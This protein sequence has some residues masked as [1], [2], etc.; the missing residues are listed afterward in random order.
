MLQERQVLHIVAG[1]H[2]WTPT[3]KDL[4]KL[5]KMFVRAATDPGSGVVATRDGVS[6][7]QCS[8]VVDTEALKP[9]RIKV[10]RLKKAKKLKA[11]K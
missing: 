6:V 2:D 9:V 10:R 5:A 3:K 4:K 11:A 1:T 7:Q 8:V